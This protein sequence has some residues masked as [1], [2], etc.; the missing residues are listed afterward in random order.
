MLAGALASVEHL[1]VSEIERATAHRNARL[2]K[3]GMERM[4]LPYLKG[5]SHIVPLIV[6][7]AVCCKAVTDILMN[8][9][10]IYVQP[11]NYPTVPKGTERLR[12]TATAAHSV[13]DID[14]MVDILGALY[15]HEHMFRAA[16]A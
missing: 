14:R 1:K 11:I 2:L 4:N 13:E 16:V 9:Y 12:L 3:D 10:D 7:D 8:D 5:E 15:S 6:G